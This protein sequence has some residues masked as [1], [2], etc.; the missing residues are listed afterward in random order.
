MN[1]PAFLG[2]SILELIN[3]LMCQFYHDYLKT[4]TDDIYKDVAEDFET[5]FDTS[6][7]KLDRTIPKGKKYSD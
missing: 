3:I 7:Y 5:R 6:N 1:K 2:L 4:E